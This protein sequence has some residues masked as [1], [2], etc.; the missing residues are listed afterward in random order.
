MTRYLALF[1]ILFGALLVPMKNLY[2]GPLPAPALVEGQYVYTI[3]AGFD[4]PMIGARGIAEMNVAASM[5]H[6]PFYVV[7]VDTL[8]GSG[9]ED[10]RAAQAVDGLAEDW[11]QDPNYDVSTSQIFLLTFNPRKFRFLAGAKF[12]NEIGFEGK[13]HEPYT[14]LFLKAATGTPKDPKS[15]IIKMMNASDD[16]LFDQTDPVKVAARQEAER[17]ARIAREEAELKAKEARRLQNAQ[18]DIDGQINRLSNLLNKKDYLPEDVSSYESLLMDARGTRKAGEPVVMR[19]FSASMKGS[20]DI[21]EQ[22]VGKRQSVARAELAG[23]IVFWMFVFSLICAFGWLIIRRKNQ[24]RDLRLEWLARRD[25]WSEQVKNASVHY[26]NFFGERDSLVSLGTIEG[27][28]AELYSEVTSEVDAIYAAVRAME[29]HLDRCNALAVKGRFLN[30]EPLR[31]AMIRLEEEFDFETGEANKNDLFAAE[32][33]TVHVKPAAFT[34][35]LTCRFKIVVEKWNALKQAAEASFK[36]SHELYSHAVLDDLLAQAQQH[37]IPESW[38]AEHPLSGDDVSDRRFW[39]ELDLLR[40]TD[41]LA[42]LKR[43]AVLKEEQ[44]VIV[45]KFDHLVSA[46][47]KASANQLT[48]V[49]TIPEM[50]LD[51][52]DDP[53]VTYDRAL[54]ERNRL[55]GCLAS[56]QRVEEVEAQ[57]NRID[58]LYR[59]CKEQDAIVQ[60]AV[61]NAG[62]AIKS[63]KQMDARSQEMHDATQTRVKDARCVHSSVSDGQ[64]S[65]GRSY[66]MQGREKLTSAIT[67]EEEKRFLRAQKLANEAQV[68]FTKAQSDY[69]TVMNRCDDLDRSKQTFEREL[70]GMEEERR[71]LERK[72]SGYGR[73]SSLGYVPPSYCREEA[74]D[75]ATLQVYLNQQRHQWQQEEREARRAYEEE[76]RRIREE[77]EERRR[78]ECR[79]REAEERKRRKEEEER[80]RRS[81]HSSG[82][83]WGGGGSSSSGGSW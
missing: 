69:Q 46:V 36:P 59:K 60:S 67:E 40:R 25:E 48:A 28:T 79:R 3:P 45:A 56:S 66:W 12:K 83:S 58:A 61:K 55:A 38:L 6:F 54:H 75:Y 31:Q 5:L 73:R 47:K 70:V 72:I 77:E 8:P 71:R 62:L 10:Y 74:Q 19:E 2:A 68:L 32:T 23:Q 29:A 49:P 43:I 64:I 4:P 15:G 51:P 37:H 76:Q 33:V 22:E 50:V 24:L 13:A 30:L 82:S 53:R 65:S 18:A 16:Y 81:Y 14:N 41:P 17:K 35:D 44:D 57:A 63:A 9:D 52:D 39:D 34:R 80:R 11:M 27:K 1:T 26:F 42:Y 78:Q 7:L 21:L 20:V